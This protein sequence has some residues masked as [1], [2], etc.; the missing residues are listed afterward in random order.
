ML[1]TQQHLLTAA[2]PPALAPRLPQFCVCAFSV[3]TSGKGNGRSSC[4]GIEMFSFFRWLPVG[5][6]SV[7]CSYFSGEQDDWNI[8]TK[9][10]SPTKSCDMFMLVF[11]S[12]TRSDTESGL[13]GPGAIV[14][15][16]SSAGRGTGRRGTGPDSA[17]EFRQI[18]DE[19]T[20]IDFRRVGHL[21][22]SEEA[23][24][25][26]SSRTS[27]RVLLAVSISAVGIVTATSCDQSLA[28]FGARLGQDRVCKQQLDF[29]EPSRT[30]PDREGTATPTSKQDGQ[31]IEGTG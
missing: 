26:T 10:S 17:A 1:A 16:R 9:R 13:E 20:E 3:S 5:F 2:G 11:H 4:R 21:P 25:K 8:E 15:A 30:I 14:G 12:F 7:L 6:L 28:Q 24:Q 31:R 19:A 27:N 23:Q 22:T 29:A 18:D